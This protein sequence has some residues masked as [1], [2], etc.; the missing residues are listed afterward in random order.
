[1]RIAVFPDAVAPKLG[2]GTWVPQGGRRKAAPPKVAGAV[3][4]L[5]Q[6]GI[7]G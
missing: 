6:P 5:A 3:G 4:V 2:A 1:M 7:R